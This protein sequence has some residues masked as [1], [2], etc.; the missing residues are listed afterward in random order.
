MEFLPPSGGFLNY[1][2]SLAPPRRITHARTHASHSRR[3]S[4]PLSVIMAEIKTGIFAKNVQKR[5][6][7]A[8]EKVGRRAGGRGYTEDAGGGRGGSDV[9]GEGCGP[10][11]MAIDHRLMSLIDTD[12]RVSPW[13]NVKNDAA[14]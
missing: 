7:R 3:V 6:N 11:G 2:S 14:R 1:H 4:N 12:P 10:A 13:K 9:T 8:Q 5:L